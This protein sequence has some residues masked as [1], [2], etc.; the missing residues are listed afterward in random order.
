[1]L[2]DSEEEVRRSSTPQRDI[3]ITSKRLLLLESSGGWSAIPL[4]SIAC[5]EV[6]EGTDGGAFVKIYFGGGLS[7]MLGVPTPQDAVSIAAS[8]A[9]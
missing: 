3:V 7:R 9:F 4:T 5:F 8:V 1:M 2:A 6:S